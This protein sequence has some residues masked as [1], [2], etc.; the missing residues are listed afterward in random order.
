MR[1]VKMCR[2]LLLLTP[3]TVGI[4]PLCIELTKPALVFT[5]SDGDN[6]TID[7]LLSGTGLW[8]GLVTDYTDEAGETILMAPRLEGECKGHKSPT[9]FSRLLTCTSL[10]GIERRKPR[11][12]IFWVFP[13]LDTTASQFGARLLW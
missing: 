12:P 10:G 1:S 7:V 5:V 11:E 6:V 2:F 3:P 13:S 4:A 8:V 9:F